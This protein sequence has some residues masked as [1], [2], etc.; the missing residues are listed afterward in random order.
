MW[1]LNP[2]SECIGTGLSKCDFGTAIGGFLFETCRMSLPVRR[3]SKPLLVHRSVTHFSYRPVPTAILSN[4]EKWVLC[5]DTTGF[6]YFIKLTT[7]FGLPF[8]P[9]SGHKIYVVCFEETRQCKS[10]II[11]M[12]LK[13]NEISLS[14]E[15]RQRDLVEFVMNQIYGIKIQRDLVVLRRTTTRFRW[16]RHELDIWN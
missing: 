6:V 13:F 1:R 10:W 12:E 4:V 3:I 5:H 9:S 14:F 7:C 11:Y 8:R 15:E 16:I 2:Y